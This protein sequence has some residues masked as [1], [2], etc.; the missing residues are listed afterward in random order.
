[1][2]T[3]TDIATIRMQRYLNMPLV[4]RCKEIATLIE[5][6]STTELHHVFP[7]LI[8][9]LFGTTDNI[10]WGLHSI[11]FKKNPQE[12]E[13]LCNFLNPQGPVFSLCYKLLPDCYLKYNFPVSYLP[14]KIRSMLEEGVIP[15]FY[16]DKIRD[17]QG[18]RAVSVLN[19]NP[20]EYYIFHFA[21][22]L[23]NPWLQVQQQENVWVN[24]E[25]VYVQLAHCYLYHFLPRDNSPVLPIIGPYIRKTPQRKLVQSPES[26]RLQT[27]RLLKTSILSPGSPNVTFTVPQQQ[28]LP[29]VWRS[30]TVVQVFLDFWLECSEE[31]QLNPRL[32][33]TYVSSVPRRHSIHSG[34]HIRLV[35][36][37]IK[38]LHEFANSAI[39]DKSA[40]DELKRIILPSVQGKIYTFLRKAIY[41]WPLDSSFR[42]ILEA[43]LSFIQPWRYFPGISYTKEGKP[44]EEERG[45]I[46][47]AYRW[48]P[49]VANNLLAYTAIFEQLLP[50]FMR[51]DLVAPKNALMLFRVTKVFSQ[52]YLAKMICEVESHMD[53][54]GLSRSRASSNQWASIVRQQILEL[55]GPTYQYVPMFSMSTAS[56]V[57]CLLSTIKQA[58]L[59]ATSLI[60]A[61]EKKRKNRRF[62]LAIWEFFN[63]EDSSDDISIEERRRVPIYLANAQQQLIEIFEINVENIPQ[64][65]IE[66]DQEYHESILST[67][68][69]HQ[70]QTDSSLDTSKPGV[71]VS[72]QKDR[73]TCQYIEYMGDPELQP[74]RSN[75]CAFLVRYFY[76]L[77]VYVNM[78]YRHKITAM[79]H[80]RGFFGSVCRQILQ[81]PTKVVKLPKRTQDGFSSGYEERIPPRLS[82]RPLANY[83]FLLTMCLGIFIAWLTNYGAFAFL[84]FVFCMWFVYIIVRATLEP[85]TRWSV[86]RFRPNTSFSVTQ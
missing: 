41:H 31:N 28:C 53:D 33:T 59:T 1:M 24:W 69:C 14:V 19:M 66:A 72:V 76:K 61:L 18:T 57:V 55:E 13:M 10:G 63:N 27:P 8:D 32:G 6:S 64:V 36:A 17:D 58:H 71:F 86:D 62:L 81:P 56:Q 74:V 45:K 16:L 40:M 54:V 50:R 70:S 30:E 65:A 37:F 26:K 42:L 52:P 85:W 2:A 25:T 60:D 11:T 5:E 68:F 38:T 20:F 12:Y 73:Q 82:L 48:M 77:C 4:Q 67:S 84:G 3:S 22:H 75:E 9:S 15:P 39:G 23:T 51:T 78:K 49:F 47:D 21:Y 44:E 34:E 29:Q 43:W 79:Y 83:S 7:I 80:Q 35:R 46:Y